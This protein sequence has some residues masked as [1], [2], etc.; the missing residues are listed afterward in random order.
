[1]LRQLS[2]VEGTMNQIVEQCGGSLK[3]I[4]AEYWALVPGS[5]T[6]AA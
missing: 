5:G 1:M 6:F 4:I 3:L 2:I